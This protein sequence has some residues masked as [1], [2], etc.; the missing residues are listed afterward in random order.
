M[1]LV[2]FLVLVAIAAYPVALYNS[3]VKLRNGRTRGAKSMCNSSAG[4]T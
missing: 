3:L 2:F 1:G 4:T